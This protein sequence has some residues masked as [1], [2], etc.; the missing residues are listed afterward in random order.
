M[1]TWAVALAAVAVAAAPTAGAPGTPLLGVALDGGQGHLAQLDPDTLR[2]LRTS[3][4]LTNGY[5]VAPALS[6][7]GGTVA[8]GSTSF[9]GIRLVDVATLKLKAEVR[10]RNLPGTRVA[11]SSWPSS[12][13]LVLLA[14]HANPTSV[15][16]VTVDPTRARIES[17]RTL[18][19]TA[20]EAARTRDGL[21]VLLAPRVGIGQARLAVASATGLRVWKVPLSAGR[22]YRVSAPFGT[23]T[24]PGLAV[25]PARGRAYV[26]DPAGR[27]AEVDLT[28][29][30]VRL[31]LLVRRALAKGINGPERSARWL[32][33]GLIALTGSNEFV[34]VS[35]GRIDVG[36]EP[37]GLQLVDVRDWTLRVVDPDANMIAVSAGVILAPAT[38][39]G[40]PLR[41]YDFAG[42]LRF[43][44]NGVSVGDGL[45]VAGNRASVGGRVLEL[46]SGRVLG[47][48]PVDPR[49]FLLATDGS[50]FPL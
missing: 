21:A 50:T 47:D 38:T 1:R 14:V 24:I 7:D 42:H 34:H 25:D 13:R 2:P 28:S 12:D 32:G 36:G 8:L 45:D 41:A 33:N 43:E 16:V 9:V 3:S 30:K 48:A 49:V 18:S 35:G 23:Q 10:V 20:I 40:A 31:H 6:P 15:L 26:L 5:V 19:G 44:L 46:P 4:F 22:R 39:A 29:G 27:V 11:A 37:A 17:V